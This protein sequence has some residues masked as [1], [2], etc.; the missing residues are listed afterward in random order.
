MFKRRLLTICAYAL[1][2]T[3]LVQSVGVSAF[4]DSITQTD[5]SQVVVSEIGEQTDIVLEDASDILDETDGSE[6]SLEEISDTTISDG[7]SLEEIPDGQTSD[8]ESSKEEGLEEDSLEEDSVDEEFTEEELGEELYDES[9]VEKL[10]ETS[11]IL[12]V[13]YLDT[14]YRDSDNTWSF[15]VEANLKDASRED[16]EGSYY[17]NVISNDATYG[18]YVWNEGCYLGGDRKNLLCTRSI[19]VD[20]LGERE[21]TYIIRKDGPTAD[22]P[23]VK[24]ETI[25]VNVTDFPEISMTPSYCSCGEIYAYCEVESIP[26]SAFSEI[27]IDT[28]EYN[29]VQFILKDQADN[30]VG[31]ANDT[32]VRYSYYDKRYDGVF[33]QLVYLQ[34]HDS[35]DAY[36]SFTF[37]KYSKAGTYDIYMKNGDKEVLV[38]E[39]GLVV[40]GDTV[41]D[42]IGQIRNDFVVG[43]DEI[44]INLSGANIDGKKVHP[45]ITTLGSDNKPLL[46]Y[47][48]MLREDEYASS[49]DGDVYYL[50]KLSNDIIES[51][52]CSFSLEWKLIFDDPNAEVKV[53]APGKLDIS[54][55]SYIEVNSDYYNYKTD[56]FE[57]KL[58]N[59]R[60]M[61]QSFDVFLCESYASDLYDAQ[62]VIQYMK[63]NAST[64][65]YSLGNKVDSNMLISTVLKDKSGNTYIPTKNKMYYLYV[66]YESDGEIKYRES[67]GSMNYYY[68]YS[69]SGS[70]GTS[71]KQY[72]YVYDTHAYVGNKAK[73]ELY[74]TK[75]NGKVKVSLQNGGSEL[76][77]ID[78]V[79]DSAGYKYPEI[80]I[81][82]LEEGI[83][84]LVI[85]PDESSV[86]GSR[87][88]SLY[89]YNPNVFY[90]D[91]Q[92]ASRE[93][94]GSVQISVYSQTE[95]LWNET[96]PVNKNDWKVSLYDMNHTLIYAGVPNQILP[97]S[98][99]K[100]TL[101]VN[102]SDERNFNEY[103]GMYVKV[104]RKYSDSFEIARYLQTKTSYYSTKSSD[105]YYKGSD[106]YGIWNGF[107][108]SSYIGTF[109]SDSTNKHGY[110]KVMTS[111]PNASVKIYKYKSHTEVA[112]LKGFTANSDENNSKTYPYMRLISAA[113][114]SNNKINSNIVYSLLITDDK[115]YCVSKADGY[116]V[117]DDT[118]VIPV[119]GVTISNNNVYIS[120]NMEGIGL[121][122]SVSPA[123]A[124]SGLG[125]TWTSADETVATV[126]G[127]GFV[128]PIG[129]GTTTI[130]VKTE[131]GKTATATV[132]VGELTDAAGNS[133][134]ECALSTGEGIALKVSDGKNI[135]D[136]DWSSSDTSV[137]KVSSTGYVSAVGSG[138]ATVYAK[139]SIGLVNEYIT[140]KVGSLPDDVRFKDDI[141]R[142]TLSTGTVKPEMVFSGAA[143]EDWDSIA[144][145]YTSSDEKVATVDALGNVTLKANG[146]T[147]ISMKAVAT[148]AVTEA[149]REFEDSITVLVIDE[150]FAVYGIGGFDKTLGDLEYQLPTGWK[151]V[152]STVSVDMYATAQHFGPSRPV[153][154]RYM[155]KPETDNVIGVRVYGE[156]IDASEQ[157]SGVYKAMPQTLQLLYF[158]NEE[159]LSFN[160]TT[161]TAKIGLGLE[162]E[163]GDNRPNLDD[164]IDWGYSFD[165]SIDLSND[166]LRYEKN[167]VGTYKLTVNK[168]GTANITVNSVIAKGDYSKTFK[169]TYKVVVTDASVKGEADVD[170]AIVK[171]VDGE[172]AP[173]ES[174]V[175]A[176]DELYIWN[177]T[178]KYG[179][180]NTNTLTFTSVDTSVAKIGKS[181]DGI[182]TPITLGKPGVITVTGKAADTLGTTETIA[183]NYYPDEPW[184]LAGYVANI[185][186][187]KNDGKYEL[188]IV[189]SYDAAS[190]ISVSSVELVDAKDQALQ[191]LT[192]STVLSGGKNILT[193]KADST[194]KSC[195]AYVKFNP[196]QETGIEGFTLKT[197]VEITVVKTMPKATVKQDGKLDIFLK[198]CVSSVC[199]TVPGEE[200]ESV[201]TVSDSCYRF[202]NLH[203][204]SSDLTVGTY[205]LC[206]E[207]VTATDLKNTAL[208]L[209]VCVK[210]Y[211]EPIKISTKVA[212]ASGSTS[213]SSSSG[214]IYIDENGYTTFKILNKA[215]K[216]S[217]K[218]V[219]VGDIT[220]K[221][222]SNSGIEYEA[223]FEND[224]TIKL[225]PTNG[226]LPKGKSDKLSISFKGMFVTEQKLNYTVKYADKASIGL[227]LDKS[228]LSLYNYGSAKL[229]DGCVATVSLKGNS[230][231]E[232]LKNAYII[233][234]ATAKTAAEYSKLNVEFDSADYTVH[235]SI[236][237]PSI[238]KGS[239]VYTIGLNTGAAKPATVKLTVKV[240]DAVMGTKSAPSVKVTAKGTLDILDGDSY[241]TLTPKFTN[242]SSDATITSELVGRDSMLFELN[243]VNGVD[244][245]ELPTYSGSSLTSNLLTKYKYQVAIKYTVACGKSTY[246]ITSPIINVTLKQTNPKVTVS[247]VKALTG[248]YVN[249]VE[250]GYLNIN[251][252]KKNGSPASY[253]VGLTS[254]S[255]NA[256]FSYRGNVGAIDLDQTKGAV[257]KGKSYKL[258]FT[259]IPYGCAANEKP[260]TVTYTVKINK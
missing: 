181:S 11:D 171:K 101:S 120:K 3:M 216:S 33:E 87:F 71:F 231:S 89:L 59:N 154:I 168:P 97:S 64:V 146:T 234:G 106:E 21:I 138:M 113:D 200:I 208:T 179:S 92:S 73:L 185:N 121:L 84:N 99:Q 139:D 56:K 188:E 205:S 165:E 15:I 178:E 242:V 145:T 41:I 124:N 117:A 172:Y 85:T 193:I 14:Y 17:I 159:P 227:A 112:T 253:G 149:K 70:G 63:D 137:A 4:A 223:V 65:G 249:G 57:I 167:A 16:Y 148:D 91:S 166:V 20:T 141:H 76:K 160:F 36:P 60:R 206:D 147:I 245:L 108:G 201:E 32:Y 221:S 31:V 126:D 256:G 45:E 105:T 246:T 173:V 51:D 183:V 29:Y 184:G 236:V 104:E 37:S 75:K 127:S 27:G 94:D 155:G 190:E 247:G 72:V 215:N 251:V 161:M 129:I 136:V 170:F 82:G 218:D 119:T 116:I 81:S 107:G 177:K 207:P 47:V 189:K 25:R 133:I 128:K 26:A 233:S 114:I 111:A 180:A 220:A 162:P 259:V 90:C 18:L 38:F 240:A 100:Y 48:K 195:K 78:V 239:Y 142:T 46:E 109:Y 214:T 244:R 140:V 194:A 115:G 197:P 152:D 79:F 22:Y 132:H 134:S 232:I 62:D 103:T 123:G 222:T 226:Y 8:E 52:E 204:Y 13:R 144:Y 156:K 24:Q 98:Y 118:K 49:S 164:F 191:G 96:N 211:S 35:F 258:T 228:S 199:I 225:K 196:E 135:F 257:V 74:Y 55:S 86:G 7:E 150:D 42:E 158:A 12:N 202:S 143:F 93:D 252:V 88:G 53:L 250:T 182:Y 229:L 260:I 54:F 5:D 125:L 130:T 67:S 235:A 6:D 1:T 192:A 95:Y 213:L 40:T 237:D 69:E 169:A 66:F 212:T 203:T 230:N 83:Y 10:E 58:W 131:G 30:V 174:G 34:N 19:P 217:F 176:K 219:A 187:N 175:F 241:I 163:T 198:N 28:P 153:M 2:F 238:K 50:F 44:V 243:K 80:D 151:F 186:T 68:N 9:K 224:D 23:I 209:K 255:P 102:D 254:V 248:S 39:N 157:S 43:T 77:S 210:G 110:Y 61:P 122:A